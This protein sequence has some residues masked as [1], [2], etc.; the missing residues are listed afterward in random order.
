MLNFS[1][2]T[3]SLYFALNLMMLLPIYEGKG[4]IKLVQLAKYLNNVCLI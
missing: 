2:L 4:I 1:F 3:E